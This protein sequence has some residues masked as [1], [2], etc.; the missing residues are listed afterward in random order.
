M[1]ETFTCG[2]GRTI[3]TGTSEPPAECD[4]D[5]RAL[6]RE[7]MTGDERAEALDSLM[8]APLCTKFGTVHEITEK[9]VGRPVWTHEFA[10]AERLV[11]EAR[12]Q[13]HPA[14]LEA[15]VI[16]SLDQLAGTKPV[17]VVRPDA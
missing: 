8:S 1:P 16:G 15:H 7:G 3:E 13:E 10:T 17:L 11:E 14:D 12:A 2:H 4:A 6:W 9:L 5:V